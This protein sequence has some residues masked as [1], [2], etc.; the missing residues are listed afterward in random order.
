LERSPNA[1]SLNE[2]DAITLPEEVRTRNAVLTS[3]VWHRANDVN[4]E[5]FP[6]TIEF[7]DDFTYIAFSASGRNYPVGRWY[8]TSRSVFAAGPR[9]S[10]GEGDYLSN[11]G[12][13]LRI[14]IERADQLIVE[15]APYVPK[16]HLGSTGTIWHFGGHGKP[17]HVQVDYDMPIRRGVPC[18]I[19]I[20]FVS[21]PE[22]H[23]QRFSITK[24]YDHGYR[25]PDG[26]IAPVDEMAALDLKETYVPTGESKSFSFTVM[27]PEAGVHSYYLNALLRGATQHW[28]EREAMTF[29]ILEPE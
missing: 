12:T 26:T 29:R 1:R 21:A 28:D 5:R 13:Y 24:E 8:A 14:N 11:Y 6:A 16:E 25:R 2:L 19:D 9:D 20:H 17:I 23:L 7:R 4:L 22:M 18:Q 3:R 15:N 27:F 10:S